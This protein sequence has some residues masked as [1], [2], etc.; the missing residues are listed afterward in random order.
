MDAGSL[1]P[2]AALTPS[3]I[4][5]GQCGLSILDW[6]F[7]RSESPRALGLQQG[8]EHQVSPAAASEDNVFWAFLQVCSSPL[9]SEAC[10]LLRFAFM[11]AR[12]GGCCEGVPGPYNSDP[13]VLMGVKI[14]DS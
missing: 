4:V 6:G 3:H 9:P 8:I 5:S 12:V 2:G 1:S 11:D 10:L 14:L 7:P 13:A